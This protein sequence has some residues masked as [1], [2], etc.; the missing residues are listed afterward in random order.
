MPIRKQDYPP[1]WPAI[2][3]AVRTEAGWRCEWCG[4]PGGKVIRRLG[5]V[6]E[7]E[8]H[9]GCSN[10]TQMYR[11]DW[12]QIF[13]DITT[14]VPTSPPYASAATCAMTSGSISP[15]GSTAGSTLRSSNRN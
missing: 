10:S 12:E 7:K 3:L 13:G 8:L 14:N 1:D 5:R 9:I 4:A 15:T 2:S 11:V 6:E